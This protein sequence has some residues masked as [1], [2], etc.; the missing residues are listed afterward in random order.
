MITVYMI[1][2]NLKAPEQFKLPKGY[3]YRFFNRKTGREDWCRVTLKTDLFNKIDEAYKTFDDEFAPFLSEMERRCIFLIDTKKDKIIGTI[4]AWYT[5]IAG[6]DYGKIHWVGIDE[7]YQGKGLGKCMINYGV[8]H[9]ATMHDIGKL[10]TQAFR[11]AAIKRYL[12]CDFVPWI[13]KAEDEGEW[14]RVEKL[15][16]HEGLR[17]R[18]MDLDDESILE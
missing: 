10:G 16:N 5:N 8:A 18:V 17:A 9:L 12:T 1:S 14:D 7:D 3:K 4:T 15:I 6:R 11:L 13:R 2:K